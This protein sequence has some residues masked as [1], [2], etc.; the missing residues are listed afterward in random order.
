MPSLDVGCADLSRTSASEDEPFEVAVDVPVITPDDY[1]AVFKLTMKL[2]GRPAAAEYFSLA[3]GR[4]DSFRL[5]AYYGSGQLSAG[6]YRVTVDA[7]EVDWEAKPAPDPDPTPDPDEPKSAAERCRDRGGSWSPFE[8]ACRFPDDSG[9][10]GGGTDDGGSSGD[11][12]GSGGGSG[13]SDRK[14]CNEEPW[15]NYCR[16]GWNLC[17]DHCTKASTVAA[18][19][20]RVRDN[21]RAIAK[22]TR[23]AAPSGAVDDVEGTRVP[24][25][26]YLDADGVARKRCGHR[27]DESCGCPQGPVCGAFSGFRA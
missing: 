26:G 5:V 16:W 15:S 9:S 27:A 2:D 22:P 18:A 1:G 8:R 6:D 3:A 12:G 25:D 10:S 7:S 19:I 24:P 17:P 13:D 23:G 4:L 14:N 21:A 11:S 20:E